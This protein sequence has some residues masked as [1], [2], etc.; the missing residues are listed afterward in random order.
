M[1]VQA[2]GLAMAVTEV[3]KRVAAVYRAVVV[4][5]E[6]DEVAKSVVAASACA[7]AAVELTVEMLAARQYGSVR[8]PITPRSRCR[9]ERAPMR[10]LPGTA[11]SRVCSTA[12]GRGGAFRNA[13]R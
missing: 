5:A 11:L 7:T 10:C 13:T 2:H 6:E 9:P 8:G 3:Q 12:T 1:P 4:G